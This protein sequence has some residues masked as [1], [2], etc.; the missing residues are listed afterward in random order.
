MVFAF[1]IRQTKAKVQTLLVMC[2]FLGFRPPFQRWCWFR[3]DSILPLS[4]KMR[5]IRTS[6]AVV[7]QKLAGGG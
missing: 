3:Q 5:K 2:N 1:Y 7:N 6:K 4:G